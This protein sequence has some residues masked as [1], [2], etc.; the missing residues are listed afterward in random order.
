MIKKYVTVRMRNGP[1][2]AKNEHLFIVSND[3]RFLTAPTF[4]INRLFY[5]KFLASS[6]STKTTIT[7]ERLIFKDM[8]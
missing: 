5:I 3:K 6:L 7:K 2:A 4:R 8:T 1:A